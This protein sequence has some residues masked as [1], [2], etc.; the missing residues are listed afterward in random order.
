MELKEQAFKLYRKSHNHP[1][2]DSEAEGK[3][4]DT[5]RSL[6]R[7]Y[8]SKVR[9]KNVFSTREIRDTVVQT[10]HKVK[11]NAQLEKASWAFLEL[12]R[13]FLLLHDFPWKREFHTL[14]VRRNLA[15]SP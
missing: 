9:F 14:K 15:L 10:V 12:E 3:M 6:L 2:F 1:S 8:L 13:Y 5:I 11:D 4:K 7:K